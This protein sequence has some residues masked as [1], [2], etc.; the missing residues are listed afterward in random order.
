M[1]D[2]NGLSGRITGK[3]RII[4]QTQAGPVNINLGFPIAGKGFRIQVAEDGAIVNGKLVPPGDY[5]YEEKDG[6]YEL[7]R[8]LELTEPDRKRLLTSWTDE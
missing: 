5:N 8:E 2:C 1:I 7:V 3:E 4:V 6:R